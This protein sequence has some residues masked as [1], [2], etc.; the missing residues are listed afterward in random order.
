MNKSTQLIVNAVLV[1][2]VAVLFFLHFSSRPAAA[3]AATPK[4]TMAADSTAEVP[5]DEVATVASAD[6]NKVAY[7]ESNKLLEG[8][9][10]MQVAR[11]SFES[12]AKGW[13]AQN[14]ALVRNFQAAVQKYQQTAQTLTNEQRAATEQ[15]LQQQEAQAGQKQQQLQQLAAQEE[16]KMTK[17]V[18]D[19]VDKQIEK[20]GKDHGYRLILISSPG[21]AIA[22]GR[23]ELDITAPV[24]KY[25]NDEYS[26]KR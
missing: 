5:V 1:V 20:Y 10:A 4:V 24:L 11:K 25:L 23:K 8:Y 16:A 7:V 14:D 6:S 9:K 26:A 19:R 15:S 22:Y 13:Q 21:G 12:K 2:A 3:P 18:L 17:T